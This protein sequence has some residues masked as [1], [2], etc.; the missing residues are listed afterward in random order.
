M[1]G[2]RLA[3]CAGTILV[4]LALAMTLAS[5]IYNAPDAAWRALSDLTGLSSY[6]PGRNETEF[7]P[8]ANATESTLSPN[9]QQRN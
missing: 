1:A 2:V 8:E 4:I 3:W 7:S 9:T 5:F 6:L